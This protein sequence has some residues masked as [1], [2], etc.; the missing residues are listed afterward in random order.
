MDINRANL[1]TLFTG[2]QAAFQG[3]FDGAPRDY[4]Q[5][6]LE[7]PSTTA[8][9]TYAWLGQTT[10]FR[11]WLGDRVIQ[12][13]KSH[14]YTIRNKSFENTV[15]VPR[16]AIEDDQYGVYTPLMAQIGQDAAEHPAGM[17][18]DLLKN[19][20]ATAGYDGQ[21][22]FDTDHPVVDANGV[23]QSVS[24]TGGG[25][26]TPWFIL[27]TT[28]M[29]KPIILQMRAPY[30]FVAKDQETDENTFM[31][32]EFLYSSEVRLNA[33]YGLWQLAYG[34]KQTLDAAA[35][36]AALAAMQG[37]KG[38]HGRPLGIRPRLLVV[39]PS[40]RAT[41]LSLV[42]AENDAAGATNIN[43]NAV[44]VLVSPWLA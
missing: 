17:V 2:Y 42:V 35:F 13:L 16:E 14:N 4:A 22:F 20:F 11:E 30:K 1:R 41:A 15:G 5:I 37:M 32:K 19:G 8:E 25:S 6:A 10:G 3:A 21:F 40:L 29:I 28:R 12:N 39:P 38:D 9:E 36:N 23:E 34:S 43:R 7:V 33:G 31:R 24:N 18:F 44:D 26:G 27:D